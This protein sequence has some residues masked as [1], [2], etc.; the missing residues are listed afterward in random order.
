M[1]ASPV[2]LWASSF[3]IVTLFADD[4]AASVF[5]NAGRFSMGVEVV[6]MCSSV[7]V[8]GMFQ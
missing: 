7:G 4:M 3:W 2:I 6:S 1:C 8:R 5:K